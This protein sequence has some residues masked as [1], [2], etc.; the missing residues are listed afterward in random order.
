MVK[1]KAF[2][3]HVSADVDCGKLDRLGSIQAVARY[4][5]QRLNCSRVS[6]WL[7]EG[8]SGSRVMRRFAAHDASSAE[9]L[10][11]LNDESVVLTD[12]EFAEYF[13]A[14]TIQGTYVSHDV[15]VDPRLAAMRETYLRPHDVRASLDAAISVNGDTWAILCCAQ[16]G[17]QRTW[18][19]TEVALIKRMANEISLRRARR[20]AQA[21]AASTFA[22]DLKRFGNNMPVPDGFLPP[23]GTSGQDEAFDRRMA[24]RLQL[25]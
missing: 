24:A 16:R 17:E 21:V 11:G 5:Q 12:A 13:D 6:F 23:V 3:A 15:M 10:G 9:S 4:I 22:Q 19:S 1:F 25:L 8:E 7:L 18:L 20:S 14:L 2:L